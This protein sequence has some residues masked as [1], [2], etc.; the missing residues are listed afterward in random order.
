MAARQDSRGTSGDPPA[1]ERSQ[2]RSTRPVSSNAS[3]Q[4]SIPKVSGRHRENVKPPIPSF[5]AAPKRVAVRRDP[6]STKSRE[7]K[8]GDATEVEGGD[9]VNLPSQN[10]STES[11]V[12]ISDPNPSSPTE[13]PRIGTIT[14]DASASGNTA[15]RV[16]TVLTLYFVE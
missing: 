6:E 8:S 16:L 13:S 9:Y 2:S 10:V 15:P 5:E 11:S 12:E 3:D 7:Y 1:G 14:D 4:T